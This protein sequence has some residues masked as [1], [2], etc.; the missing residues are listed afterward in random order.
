[1][2]IDH[3]DS[4]IFGCDYF[5][6]IIQVSCDTNNLYQRYQTR[7]Y[8]R[9][10]TEENMEAELLMVVYEQIQRF[11]C[12]IIYVEQNNPEDTQQNVQIIMDQI[13]SMKQ[14][15]IPEDK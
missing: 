13:D 8:S 12:P 10:K 4:E 15:K 6:L 2:I 3:H 5:D 1:M 9:Q 14:A 7:Q 11:K